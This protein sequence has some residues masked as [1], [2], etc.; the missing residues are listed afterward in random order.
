MNKDYGRIYCFKNK[1][2]RM[3]Y[4]GQTIEQNIEKY[5]KSKKYGNTYLNRAIRK[6]GWENFDKKVIYECERKKNFN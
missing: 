4:F 3:Q 5:W 6:Y 2:D 1:I